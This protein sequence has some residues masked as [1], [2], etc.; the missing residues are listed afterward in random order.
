MA[1]TR[2]LVKRRRHRKPPRSIHAGYRGKSRRTQESSLSKENKRQ[3]HFRDGFGE[4]YREGVQSGIQSY[5]TVFEGT[6][7]VIPTFDQLALLKLCINSIIGNTNPPY[8]IIVVDNASTD[9]TADYLQ[10]LGGQVRYRVLDNNRG[11]AGAINIGMMMAK[12]RTIVLLNNDTLVTEKWLDNLLICLHSDEGIGMVGPVTNYISGDQQIS[13]PYRDVADM[14]N[15]AR[16]NNHSN[17]ARWHRTDRLTGFCLLFRRELFEGNG[18]F[19]EGFEIGNFEDDDYNIRVRLLG[20]SLVMAQD[21]FIHHFGSVSMKA[22]GNRF[23]E[24]NERNRLYFMD[25]WQN[26]YEWIH[27][28]KQHPELVQGTL[29]HIAHYYPEH[30]V[31]QAIGANIYWIEQGMRRLVVGAL[32]F[33]STR[34]SQVDLRR[35]PQ[36]EPILAEEVEQRWRG[37]GDIS[38]L[39]ASVVILPDGVYYHLERGK[40][41]R[42]ISSAAMQAWNLHLKPLKAI[43]PEKLED[44]VQGLPIISPPLLRQIL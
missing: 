8:E 34:M 35:W 33:P 10:Q 44:W 41:R 14:P 19:D 12:G 32:T 21:T 43:T 27:Q 28:A 23:V 15:F 9:G 16:E 13:V 3:I 39:E 29:P 30:I 26:P 7:I 5:P 37:L 6:S 11:F 4:G 18:Y 1:V 38:G 24:I 17:I 20:K 2:T 40:V 25:K 22:L 42:I 31:V 36:G